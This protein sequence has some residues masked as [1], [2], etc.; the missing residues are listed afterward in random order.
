MSFSMALTDEVARIT[1]PARAVERLRS[2]LADTGSP[3]FLGPVDRVLLRGAA[4]VGPVAPRIVAAGLRWRLRRE[5]ASIVL[6]AEDPAFTRHVARRRAEGF[7]LNVNLLGEAILGDDE[8]HRRRDDLLARI[9]RPDVDYVSVKISAVSA[10]LSSL[11]FDET[12]DRV[13]EALLPLYRRAM[14]AE[15]RVFVNLDME[16]YRDLAL[17]LAAFERILALPGLDDADVGIVLQAYLPDSHAAFDDIARWTGERRRRGGGAVKVRIVKGANLAMER[18]DAEL[19]GWPAAP[20]PT[21]ADVD[22][23]VQAAD[24]PGARSRSGGRAPCR[25]GVPQHLRRGVG[26]RAGP[27]N[28]HRGPPRHRDARG[29]GPG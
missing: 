17:T 14:R 24:R 6:D 11:A 13:V 9:D 16:E 18:V 12:V 27:P 28:G 10:Q 4:L 5:S 23:L 22:A 7:R 19:H 29:H 21:K 1:D 8:A 3:R 20:Y 15:P 26:H 2:L 25:A